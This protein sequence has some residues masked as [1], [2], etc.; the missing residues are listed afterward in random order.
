MT[1]QNIEPILKLL[2]G[3]RVFILTPMPRYLRESCCDELEHAPNRYS[4]GFEEGL[5][6]ALSEFRTN[7]K[8][9]IFTRGLRG[10]KVIDPSPVLPNITGDFNIWGEDP[11]HPLAE[12]YERVVD[13]LEK[14]LQAKTTGKRAAPEGAGGQHKKPRAEMARPGWIEGSSLSAKRN[15]GRGRGG[16][17]SGYSGSGYYGGGRGG[18]GPRGRGGWRR[19]FRGRGG[20]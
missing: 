8:N 13:L 9:F 12:G 6:K 11:V 19:P 3:W 15:D 7:H 16:Y 4:P 5:R 1:F 14:E 10:F 18:N 20:F 17:Y 2:E